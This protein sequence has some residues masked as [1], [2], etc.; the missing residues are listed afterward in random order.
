MHFLK[1]CTELY[2][3]D[4]YSDTDYQRYQSGVTKL[5]VSKDSINKKNEWHVAE[6]QSNDINFMK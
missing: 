3:A 5:F 4:L 2:D 1:K 6:F